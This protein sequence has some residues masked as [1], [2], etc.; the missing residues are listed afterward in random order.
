MSLRTRKDIYSAASI[1]NIEKNE[2]DYFLKD[3]IKGE[4]FNKFIVIK[5]TRDGPKLSWV[6]IGKSDLSNVE[7]T[8]GLEKGDV[9]YI[10]PSKGLLDY[11]EQ[12]RKRVEASI[13]I[14]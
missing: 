4:N 10:L 6:E 8:N 14:G 2:I 5:D 13:S 12:F 3:K 11:Q 1:L 9:V 7:V